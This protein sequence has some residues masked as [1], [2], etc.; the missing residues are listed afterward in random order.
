MA[1]KT[2]EKFDATK[3]TDAQLKKNNQNHKEI[4]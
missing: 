3:M 4:H 2:N 1:K